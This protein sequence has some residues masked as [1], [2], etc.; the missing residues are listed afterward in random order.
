MTENERKELNELIEQKKAFCKAY[1]ELINSHTR[2]HLESIDY[3]FDEETYEEWAVI[4]FNQYRTEKVN[5]SCDSRW[6]MM[7]DI[8][9]E[10][11]KHW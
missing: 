11:E 1:C 10:L 9:E 4:R 3:K 5:V 6:G 7:M 8:M 2:Q